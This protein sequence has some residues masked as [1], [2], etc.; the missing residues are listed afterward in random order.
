MN[1]RS[2]IFYITSIKSLLKGLESVV[3]LKKKLEWWRWLGMFIVLIGLII[4]G[5]SDVIFP[6]IESLSI[7]DKQKVFFSLISLI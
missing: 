1:Y 5:V 4:V 7:K 3:F 2:I 6:V